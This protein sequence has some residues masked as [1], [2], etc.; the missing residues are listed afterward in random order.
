MFL[1]WVGFSNLEGL[2]ISSL[3][4]KPL[5]LGRGQVRK[6][7]FKVVVDM[8][9]VLLLSLR[10]LIHSLETVSAFMF[11]KGRSKQAPSRADLN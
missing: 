10:E 2:G 6:T 3:P 8:F 4:G 5:G 11:V 1:L 7:S 9:T